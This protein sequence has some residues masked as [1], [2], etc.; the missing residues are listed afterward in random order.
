[1]LLAERHLTSL[2]RVLRGWTWDP[3]MPMTKL[4]RL[5][6][7]RLWVRHR[8]NIPENAPQAIKE[9]SIMGVP[10]NEIGTAGMERTGVAFY[11]LD[12]TQVPIT[13]PAIF[14]EAALQTHQGQQLL[15]PHKKVLHLPRVL[16]KPR[17]RILRPDELLVREGVHRGLKMHEH[18]AEMMF[19]GFCD[20]LGFNWG[21]FTEEQLLRMDRR[22]VGVREVMEE[23]R[24]A[25]AAANA[26][27][28]ETY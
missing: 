16:E 20:S 24:A 10:W 22:E 1:M 14:S 23:K 5:E 17:E 12:G 27:D 9:M 19:W 11:D 4:T 21:T 25:A 26:A 6:V 7:I 2:W 3:Q 28:A 13:H 15:Y 18:W 8:Y